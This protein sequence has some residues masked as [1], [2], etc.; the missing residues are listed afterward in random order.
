MQISLL[1]NNKSVEIAIIIVKGAITM[2][3]LIIMVGL[4]LVA[5]AKHVSIMEFQVS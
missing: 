2:G 5:N 1:I 4:I 3:K